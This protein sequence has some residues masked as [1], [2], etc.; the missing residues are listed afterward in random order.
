M[1]DGQQVESARWWLRGRARSKH[2]PLESA[3]LDDLE[4]AKK[5]FEML[6]ELEQ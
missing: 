5:W 6:W 4:A 3:P 2:F 1:L